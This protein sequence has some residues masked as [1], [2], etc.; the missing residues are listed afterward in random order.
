VVR[1]G[2]WVQNRGELPQ[3]PGLAHL[4][5]TGEA[6]G[7]DSLTVSDHV[8]MPEVTSSPYPFS[9]DGIATWD[10][11]DP[12]YD[13]IVAMTVC[14]TVTTR[15]EIGVGVLVLPQRH[16]IILAKQLASLDV[17]ADGRLM[18][19]VGAGWLAEEFDALAAPFT[20]R[21]ARMDEW[22][23]LLRDQW[24]GEP[25]AFDGQHYHL[26]AGVLA[27]PRPVG[28]IPILVGGMSRAALR[29]AAAADGWFA[30]QRV[31]ALDPDEVREG[32]DMIAAHRGRESATANAR[33]LLRVIGDARS[34]APRLPAFVDAGVTDVVVNADL[35]DVDRARGTYE[36]LRD[37]AD[38]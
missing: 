2:A 17:I 13:A 38:G 29:R 4:A 1:I 23:Q 8:I 19:G 18:L 25:P 22:I 11:R 27:Y 30:L 20:G 31:D 35:T 36:L 37:A 21:G 7:F 5:R 34:L 24:S 28:R 3:D 15:P 14:A 26:P 6:A 10:P 33:I 32:A 12:W 9:A 16:P